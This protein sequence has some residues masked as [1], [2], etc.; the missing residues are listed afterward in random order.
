VLISTRNKKL[1]LNLRA[2]GRIT[3]VIP[4]A[5]AFDYKG[6][7]LVAVPHEVDEVRIL[8][9]LGIEAPSPIAHHYKWSGR[10]KPFEAQEKTSAFLT[11]NPKAFV[12]SDLG[13]GKTMAALW[14]YDFLRSTGKANKMLI[15]SPLSTLERTWADEVF[16]HFPHLVTAGSFRRGRCCPFEFSLMKSSSR[17]DVKCPATT[18]PMVRAKTGNYT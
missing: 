18:A 16:Q 6:Q 4:T 5:R 14:A 13:T 2:P 12:L 15:V 11:L 9:N 8:R 1:V 17:A 7:T 3:T 10:Y